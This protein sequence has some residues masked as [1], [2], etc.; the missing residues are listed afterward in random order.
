M[1]QISVTPVSASVFLVTVEHGRDRTTHEVTVTPA[2][3][4]RYA[5]AGTTP[6]R[7]VEASFEFLLQRESPG[8]ILSAFALPVIER[9][10][11]DYPDLVRTML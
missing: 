5:E 4:A 9:Y 1:P 3:V 10:F 2:D 11:P 7:L 6:E 8:A